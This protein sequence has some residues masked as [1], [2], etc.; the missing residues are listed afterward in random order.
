[1]MILMAIMKCKNNYK[2][3][4]KLSIEW[5]A[6]YSEIA[7]RKFDQRT[8]AILQEIMIVKS[9]VFFSQRKFEVLMNIGNC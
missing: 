2:K 4:K 1:M 8:K 6:A 5:Q 7:S 3:K 9:Q